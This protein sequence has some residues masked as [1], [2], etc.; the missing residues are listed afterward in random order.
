MP[1][2]PNP[3]TTNESGEYGKFKSFMRRLVAVPHYCPI[4][5]AS[6]ACAAQSPQ[7]LLDRV[8]H[9]SCDPVL[10]MRCY[11][12]SVVLARTVNEFLH[13]GQDSRRNPNRASRS[14]DATSHENLRYKSMNTSSEGN[15][16]NGTIKRP[17]GFCFLT[18]NFL[19][20]GSSSNR[21]LA[22]S[23]CNAARS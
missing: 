14:R 8:F 3:S 17:L 23:D 20:C 7:N 6:F 18:M 16:F 19:D 1:S 10:K 13:G 5:S 12:A 9:L 2:R 4:S 11:R 15:S 21:S 22:P